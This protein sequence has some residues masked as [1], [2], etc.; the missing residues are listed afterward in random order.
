MVV[1]NPTDKVVQ[2]AVLA[3]SPR[4]KNFLNFPLLSVVDDDRTGLWLGSKLGR[5]RVRGG[6]PPIELAR[7]VW[8]SLCGW[9][10]VVYSSKS[11][12]EGAWKFGHNLATRSETRLDGR[13]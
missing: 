1:S 3:E 5:Q 6:V 8:P 4:V 2:E 11:A 12:A 10:T 7:S 13:P 9:K